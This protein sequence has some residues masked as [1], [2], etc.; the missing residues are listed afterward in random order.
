MPS[1]CFMHMQPD[2]EKIPTKH[3]KEFL[4]LLEVIELPKK[5]Q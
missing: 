4:Q 3:Q 5:V 2:W 1:W